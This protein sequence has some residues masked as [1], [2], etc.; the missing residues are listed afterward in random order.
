MYLKRLDIQGFKSFANKTV[1]EFAPGVTCVVGPNGTGK[2]NVADAVRWVLGEH[3]SRAIRA[4]KT[5]DV[6]FAGSD[7]RAQMGVAEVNI[8]LDNS[9]Q[10]LPIA[11]D[12]VVVTRRA[13]RN[14]ENE[15]LI[16]H[17]KVRLRDVV[18]L[19][20]R[21]QVGQNSYAFM[22][23][24]M[25]EQALSLRPEDRRALIE[26]AADVRIYRNKLEDASNKLRA[27]RENVE[28]VRLLVR[29]IEPR[30]SQLERQSVR[31]V[32]HQELTRELAS[33][34]H[35][36]YA[37]QWRDVNEQLLAA[38]TTQDQ[39]AE[40]FER[41]RVDAQ[42][43]EAGL[44]QLRAAIDERRR[45]IAAR[46][47]RLRSM[48]DYVRD[49]ERRTQIDNER[50]AMAAERVAELV[51]ELSALRAELAAQDNIAPPPDTSELEEKL[52]LAQTA[53]AEHRARA[54][55]IEQELH[56]LQ[57]IA[58]VSEQAAARERAL[59]DDLARRIDE[60][61]NADARLRRERD[62]SADARRKLITEVATWAREYA[63][64][65][66]ESKSAAVDHERMSG[67]RTSPAEALPSLRQQAASLDADLRRMRAE[68]DAAQMRLDLLKTMDI[69]PQAPD[70]GIRLILE[71]GGIIKREHVPADVE[72][73]GV[74]GLVG[75]VLRVS[76]GV[77]R[78]I[79]AAL[80]ENIFAVIFDRESDM[81]A[82]VNL[83]LGGDA[84]R[85]T[86]YALDTVQETRPVHL[87]KER[88]VLGVASSLVRC[89]SRYRKLVDTLL[90]RTV[91]V[92]NM[93]L[94]QRFVRRGIA[95]AVA[96]VD[97]V[98]LRPV[99]SV[100]AGA[101]ASVEASFALD[102]E[103]GDLPQE[104]ERLQPLI[105]E[106]EGAL[107]EHSRRLDESV[108]R[109][110]ELDR[111]LE[112]AR[113]RV[114]RADAAL[115]QQRSRLTGLSTR[116]LAL[117]AESRRRDE[118]IGGHFGARDRMESERDTRTHDAMAAEEKLLD[119]R[120]AIGELETARTQLSEVIAEHAATIA[121][122]EGELRGERQAN[123]ADA[124]LRGRLE[125]QIAAKDE[126][127]VRLEQDA[128]EIAGRL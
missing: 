61:S 44:V 91:I 75:Q 40:Q 21:A 19:F 108:A 76:P 35:V 70:A 101:I 121:H 87:I 50:A 117:A 3:A 42:A 56:A 23:Q 126:Q 55:N 82:A 65:L 38:M 11:F 78:A 105:T 54:A 25:V 94:A 89:D 67:Q 107:A 30:I 120:R 127:R 22:G 12:E 111:S 46:E 66:D 59:V 103:I 31:V 102:R 81:R 85:A 36:W 10:W 104:I 90:G 99:G 48:Q 60:T 84:G 57:R 109:L 41:A 14:G 7:K 9:K 113:L 88:G 13:Y 39:C 62:G 86:M 125:S 8:A 92:D 43:C 20:M 123:S 32:K 96:T 114:S 64:L 5:E 33:T 47:G 45:E 95:N 27:T 77:E 83:L 16:N 26:E 106:R 122:F 110:D 128:R 2:T 69:Q 80:A 73:D 72:L 124:S 1:L 98:L 52:A 29:E 97:G 37:H 100:S 115:A 112:G 17:A 6:I 58:L 18:E 79:E 63:R 4:R 28:R 51:A 74:R 116:L 15:Y 24:G 34:L 53:L 118:E 119:A 68:L 71:A 93:A 49:L